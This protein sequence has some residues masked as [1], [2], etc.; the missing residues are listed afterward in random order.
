LRGLSEYHDNEG[1]PKTDMQFVDSL[2]SKTRRIWEY[3]AHDVWSDSRNLWWVNLIRILNITVNSFLD[4]DLQ[5]RACAMTYRTLLA[6]V[7]AL[8]L[9]FAIGRGFG[10]QNLLQDELLNI[11]PAQR[12]VV[13]HALGFVDSYLNQASEGIFVGIGILFLLWTLISLVSSVESAFNSIWNVKEGRSIWRQITD[14]TAMF[15]ILPILMICAGGLS[16]LVSSSMRAL[17]D[18]GFVTPLLK[19]VFEG[20]SYI[21]TWLFFTGVFI[22]IPNTKVQFKY[23]LIAGV[24]TGT[25]FMILQWIFLTGQLYVAKYNAIYGSFSFL[26]LLLIW[27]QLVWVVTLGGCLICY[28]GQNVFRYSFYDKVN[29]IAHDYLEE[30]TIAVAAVIVN[31]F[32]RSLPPVTEKDITVRYGI[33]TRLAGDI[34]DRLQR[35]GVISKVLTDGSNQSYGYQPSVPTDTFTLS[36]LRNAIQSLGKR[37]FIPDFNRDFE[38]VKKT[39]G[40]V[41]EAVRSVEDSVLIRSLAISL[42]NTNNQ[43]K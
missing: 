37:N 42:N 36:N 6:I 21:F 20:A 43:S 4:S 17:F 39:C 2:I 40:M 23:A 10:F 14:Y 41:A 12:E 32:D 8:A 18:I 5:S 7:P 28:A 33:P 38:S 30:V 19:W 11:F 34:L 25:V 24:I 22:L 3:C 29:N 35:C 26:P 16:M 27:M 15:M 9:V 13:T 1:L 31:N